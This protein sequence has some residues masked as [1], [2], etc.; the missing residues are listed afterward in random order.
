MRLD[1]SRK[2]PPVRRR[3]QGI[4]AIL[5]PYLLA[6]YDPGV[7]DRQSLAYLDGPGEQVVNGGFDSDTGWTKGTNWAIGGGTANATAATAAQYLEQDCLTIGATYAITFTVTAS[8]NTCKPFAGTQAG[9][10]VGTGTHT[11]ILVANGIALKFGGHASGFTGTIDNVSVVELPACEIDNAPGLPIVPLA[12]ASYATAL[13]YFEG[14]WDGDGQGCLVNLG[15]QHGECDGLATYLTATDSPMG[16]IGVVDVTNVATSFLWHVARAAGDSHPRRVVKIQT[17]DWRVEKRD[18]GGST[19]VTVDAG[20]SVGTNPQT[21]A[22]LDTGT[23]AWAWRNEV[24][25]GINGDSFD[26]G[27]HTLDWATVGAYRANAVITAQ[28]EAFVR[29][30]VVTTGGTSTQIQAADAQLRAE[31]GV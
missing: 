30:V 15:G 7:A 10:A 26:V 1:L 25:T 19:Q 21:I 14:G 13:K 24:L 2:F 18:N 31:H 4:S 28:I 9:V 27:D 29:R 12:A 11:Q 8:A 16:F 22:H 5:A 23:T 20:V 17:T 3:L 6:D